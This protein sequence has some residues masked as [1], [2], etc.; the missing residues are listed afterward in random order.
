MDTYIIDI[1]Y[2]CLSLFGP[3]CYYILP[4]CTLMV[5]RLFNVV[6][7]NKNKRE[8]DIK[9]KARND[10]ILTLLL[11]YSRLFIDFCSDSGCFSPVIHLFV[12]YRIHN[13][14]KPL[15]NINDSLKS[16]TV[17]R[18]VDMLSFTFHYLTLDVVIPLLL[19]TNSTPKCVMCY[20]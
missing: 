9:K 15:Q 2:Y 19:Y 7:K 18:A 17:T 5:S 1:K 10:G 13:K 8:K 14:A 16:L 12:L 3:G 6:K 20:K 4:H 11:H